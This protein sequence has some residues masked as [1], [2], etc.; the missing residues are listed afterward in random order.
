LHLYR[1]ANRTDQR[2]YNVA[3]AAQGECLWLLPTLHSSIQLSGVNLFGSRQFRQV[4][5][6]AFIQSTS[7]V[8]A[9]APFFLVTWDYSFKCR[10]CTAGCILWKKRQTF[11]ENHT[12][13]FVNH[14]N[15][16]C[17]NCTSIFWCVC[18]APRPSRQ[19]KI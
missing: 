19:N 10:K 4:A 3:Y 2:P 18:P 6:D 14:L 11:D 7:S 8:Q 12:S 17:S 16:A 9:V 15:L 1:F 5:A 13:E